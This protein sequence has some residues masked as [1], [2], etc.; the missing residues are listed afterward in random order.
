MAIDS[1][2]EPVSL[3]W[4]IE[5]ASADELFRGKH[6][7]PF[8]R[9]VGGISAPG[10]PV[11]CDDPDALVEDLNRAEVIYG[12]RVLHFDL[13]AL[14]RHH[15][16]DYDALAAKTVDTFVLSQLVW[17]TGAKGDREDYS[18]DG[19]ARR[20]GH[21]GKSDNLKA[22]ADKH[23]GY[24]KIPT[25]NHAYR[26]YLRGDLAATKHVYDSFRA[27]GL[28]D[29][30][31]RELRVAAIQNR[32]TLNGWRIDTE[33]LAERVKQERERQQNAARVL[34]EEHGMPLAP[35]DKIRMLAKADWPEQFRS[36]KV[37]DVR[38]LFSE[39]ELVANGL[40][41]RV[42]QEPYK[43]PWA[44]TPGKTAIIEAFAA[45]GAPHY[46]KT[47]TGDIRMGKE[48]L[49]DGTW[50]DPD[51]AKSRPGM[52][53]AYPRDQ[54]PKVGALV[55]TILEA[56][57]ATAKYAEIQEWLC[58]D[59][60]HPLVS[61]VQA[62][63]RWANRHPANGNV[64]KRGDALEQRRVYLPDKGH[65][66]ITCDQAQVDVRAV[67][68]HA[69]D[70]AFIELLQP[71]RD[72]H[73]DMAEVYFGARTKENR[74]R[75][76]P[77]SHGVNYG[78]GAN[79]IAERNGLDRALV[80]RAL[81]AREEA[82]P[83]LAEWTEEIRELGASGQLLDNGFGRLMKCDPERAY[84]QAPA[85]MGQGATRD[86]M[87]ESL[88]RLV[89]MGDAGGMN[90]RPYLRGVVHD[91]VILSVPEDE[92]DVWAQELWNAFTWEWRGVPILCDVSKPATNWADAYADE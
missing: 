42:P 78:Q 79:A 60:V 30:A 16:A 70:A 19:V 57:G 59:R 73:M 65:V 63:G 90:V 32:M 51:A 44:T 82:F 74:K 36:S 49:S 56:T 31:R 69:Q 83:R 22:L 17:P 52:L 53:K 40:A 37:T 89:D 23:G 11:L 67:A 26:Q 21:K 91:E 28:S 1:R 8:V 24:D 72:F 34:H 41:V 39:D 9:L 85:L 10:E 6:E 3:G 64:G 61:D 35:P 50:Y 20:L 55:D 62:S 76:K 25:D 80:A 2:Y 27:D 15:G 38:A 58:G 46:P 12:H 48:A 47:K 4:D 33:L 43:S 7:G 88:L 86:I 5:T 18:L 29:Y 92:A 75:A 71:G 84:T 54:F 81:R 77:I 87:C 66:L 13:L 68:A 14:A 45:A